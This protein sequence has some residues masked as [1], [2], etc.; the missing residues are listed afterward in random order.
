MKKILFITLVFSALIACKQPAKHPA[1][2]AVAIQPPA[3]NAD[4]AYSY[5]QT[6][7]DFGPRVPNSTAHEQC[8]TFLAAKLRSFGAQVIE[9]RAN[10][11]TFDGTS[12]RAVNIIGSYKPT[13]TER[14]LLF[15]HWDSRPWADND[16]NPANRNKGVPAANDGASGVGVLLEMARQLQQKNPSIGVDLIFFDAEDYGAPENYSGNSEDSWCLGTQYWCKNPHQKGYTARFGILL[17]MVGAPDATF[18]KEGGSMYFAPEIVEKVWSKAQSLGFG[19]Y[20]MNQAI[21]TI[22]DDHIYVNKMAG[23][24]SIDLI[25]YRNEGQ[26]SG[27]GHYWHTVNDTM[28]NIDKNTLL[29]VGTT[30]MHVVYNE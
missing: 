27:F 15:S 18:Y 5:I 19:K 14:V 30:L 22:T 4:S 6:Q 13:S 23:I 8:G 28:D 2:V 7:V 20:F 10:L 12:I 17:D 1:V 29:A 25:H 26:N 16:P 11:T 24:P 21:G 9:Q 3:F